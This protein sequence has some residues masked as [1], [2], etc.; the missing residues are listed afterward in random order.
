M[1]LRFLSLT[2]ALLPSF[3]RLGGRRWPSR[4]RGSDEG[5]PHENPLGGC[6]LGLSLIGPPSPVPPPLPAGIR[7]HGTAASIM[8]GE[9]PRVPGQGTGL[10]DRAR[11]CLRPDCLVI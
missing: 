7:P 3:S 4:Q 6:H 9:A 1:I 11:A 2:A 10:V 8:T 5:K